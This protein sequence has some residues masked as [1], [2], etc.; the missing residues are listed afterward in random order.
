M[1]STKACNMVNGNIETHMSDKSNESANLLNGSM[2][3]R[4]ENAQGSTIPISAKVVLKQLAAFSSSRC[5]VAIGTF[6]TFAMLSKLDEDASAAI[7][8]INPV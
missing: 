8:L 2:G 4:V 7:A 3:D 1:H 6:I 5:L